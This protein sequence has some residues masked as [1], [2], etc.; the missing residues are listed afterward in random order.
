[1]SSEVHNERRSRPLILSSLIVV[2]IV[3]LILLFRPP[4]STPIITPPP[5]APQSGGFGNA[6]LG[7]TMDVQ[8]TRIEI[9]NEFG[10]SALPPSKII[11]DNF[12]A[13]TLDSRWTAF[14]DVSIETTQKGY[15][16]S[17]GSLRLGN[18]VSDSNVTDVLSPP[19]DAYTDTSYK[20]NFF[21][22]IS[23]PLTVNIGDESEYLAL[24]LNFSDGRQL[25]YI[26]D[27]RYNLPNTEMMKV[28][29]IAGSI[30]YGNWLGFQLPAIESDF[31]HQFDMTMASITQI[32][33]QY[34]LLT[35][36]DVLVFLDNFEFI[37]S[38][39]QMNDE[40]YWAYDTDG[41]RLWAWAVDVIYN[42]TIDDTRIN[43]SNVWVEFNVF[44]GVQNDGNDFIIPQSFLQDSLVQVTVFNTNHTWNGQV[45][46]VPDHNIAPFNIDYLY[47]NYTVD[48]T[49]YGQI[50]NTT[51]WMTANDD[52]YDGIAMWWID[53]D[54]GAISIEV[55]VIGAVGS[56]AVIATAI[57]YTRSSHKKEDAIE[58]RSRMLDDDF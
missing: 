47:Y 53:I 36:S 4:S 25:V 9:P 34:H 29:D 13:P 26:V 52:A 58:Q 20:I 24:V 48:V 35:G 32:Q 21:A 22:N 5:S 55:Q 10:V 23:E 2:C 1:M 44:G 12:D 41:H 31:Y 54:S 30:V 17:D 15:L 7:G 33:I 46:T 57:G 42:V 51:Q 16:R 43:A 19:I 11:E 3:A 14:G 50:I 8:I 37:T 45:Y 27:G 6:T 38:P 39:I 28:V 49:A 56:V 18:T 40:S